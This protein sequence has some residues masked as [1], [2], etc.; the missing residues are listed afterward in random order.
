MKPQIKCFV[1][2]RARI[3]AMVSVPAARA[4]DWRAVALRLHHAVSVQQRL[5]VCCPLPELVTNWCGPPRPLTRRI[6]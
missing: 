6:D 1:C 5:H 3:A 4:I 2:L